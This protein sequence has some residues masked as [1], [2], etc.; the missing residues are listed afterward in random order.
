MSILANDATKDGGETDTDLTG[1]KHSMRLN[2]CCF[3]ICPHCLFHQLQHSRS[4]FGGSS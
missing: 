4:D 2:C 3:V 1:D